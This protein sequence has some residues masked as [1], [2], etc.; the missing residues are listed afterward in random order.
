M[1]LTR[2]PPFPWAV[3]GLFALAALVTATPRSASACSCGGRHAPHVYVGEEGALPRDALGIPWIDVVP[4]DIVGVERRRGAA[5]SEVRFKVETE[6]PFV[7]VVPEG[8]LLEGADYTVFLGDRSNATTVTIGG[9]VIDLEAVTLV[10][11]PRRRSRVGLV[12][13]AAKGQCSDLAE[14][15]T[16]V[17]QAALPPAIGRYR[18]YLLYEFIVDGARFDPPAASLCGSERPGRSAR[19]GPGGEVL[20]TTCAEGIG[21]AAGG[22]TVALAIS[23]PD[24]RRHVTPTQALELDCETS[25]PP[26]AVIEAAAVEPPEPAPTTEEASPSAAPPPLAA[27][28]RLAE[29]AP[30]WALFVLLV[31]RRRGSSRGRRSS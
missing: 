20:F 26:E 10:L 30:P 31:G 13:L 17:A 22:H 18:D 28:C 5:V 4:R 6:G 2:S 9:D 27:G 19:A 14:A 3:A 23:T 25:P 7:I 29:G 12:P 24:G 11:G 16:I 15:D 1:T 21:L 8:G